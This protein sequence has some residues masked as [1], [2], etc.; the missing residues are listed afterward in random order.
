[1]GAG[2][3]KADLD[4]ARLTKGMGGIA[5]VVGADGLRRTSRGFGPM[6]HSTD[7]AAVTSVMTAKASPTWA[8][9]PGEVA[10][11]RGTGN[12][13]NRKAVSERRVT[14]RSPRCPPFSGFSICV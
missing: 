4:L 13:G 10:L 5:E 12:D 9:Q 11:Q 14:V 6:T 8:A 3:A 7:S 2:E 1:M